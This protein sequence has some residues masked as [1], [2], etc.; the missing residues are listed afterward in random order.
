MSELVLSK[1]SSNGNNK[2]NSNPFLIREKH[3]HKQ[4]RQCLQE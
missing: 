1:S 3:A 2:T 4:L